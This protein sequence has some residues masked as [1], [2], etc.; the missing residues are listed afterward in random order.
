MAILKIARMGHPV[1]QAP[2]EAVADAGAPEIT[3]LIADMIETMADAA[4]AG[5]AAPQVHVPKRVVIF[6]LPEGRA[7][8]GGEGGEDGNG[9]EGGNGGP[10]PPTVLINPVVE[11]LDDEVEVDWE[12]CLSLPDMIGAV[13]RYV[14]IRYRALNPDG[15]AIE[16]TAE[17]F[18]AR[19]VQH[20]CDHLDGILYPM[21]MPDL[22]LFGFAEEMR[23]HVPAGRTEEA[24]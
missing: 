6:H 2:A 5:L 19:V 1:L 23:R 24:L 16:R 20:E 3:R 10:R 15:E 14:R 7:G 4:G 18:H 9:G 13:P 17:G 22:T 8:N 12:G 11:P 21:R